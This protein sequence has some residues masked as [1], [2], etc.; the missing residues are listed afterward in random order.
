MDNQTVV[1][2]QQA[3]WMGAGA[4]IALAIIVIVNFL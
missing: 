4:Y 3:A 1:F 2:T